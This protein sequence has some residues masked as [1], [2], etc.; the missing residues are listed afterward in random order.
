MFYF[1]HSTGPKKLLVSKGREAEVTVNP[2]GSFAI[3]DI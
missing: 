3:N 2:A 1:E